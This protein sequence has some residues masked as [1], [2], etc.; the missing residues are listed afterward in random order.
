V[1]LT[2]LVVTRSRR[3]AVVDLSSMRRLSWRLAETFLAVA[4]SKFIIW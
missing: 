1:V 2:L 3:R 4:A